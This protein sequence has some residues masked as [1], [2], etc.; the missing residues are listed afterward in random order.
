L[1][2]MGEMSY[3][4]CTIKPFIALINF[5]SS[6]PSA[7]VVC[8]KA[9]NQV[10]L[11]PCLRLDWGGVTRVQRRNNYPHGKCNSTGPWYLGL[12]PWVFP[13]YLK[14]LL[15]IWKV[16]CPFVENLSGTTVQSV[17]KLIRMLRIRLH[18]KLHF[19]YLKFKEIDLSS[20][21]WRPL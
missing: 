16:R 5:V 7:I 14:A 10:R 8:S 2:H 18:L 4:T 9:L 11:Q 6:F 19:N 3:G 17:T 15:N 1:M 21:Q 13:E 20:H 12:H